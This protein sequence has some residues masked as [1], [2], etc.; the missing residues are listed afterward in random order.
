MN[1]DPVLSVASFGSETSF[2]NEFF[3]SAWRRYGAALA[4]AAVGLAARQALG[5]VLHD[6]V[7]YIT[8]FPALIFSVLFC[9]AGPTLVAM[10]FGLAGA[11]F[12]VLEPTRSFSIPGAAELPGM[13][14]FLAV[15]SV[16][17][18][19][20]EVH[21]R[22]MEALR[23]FQ[24]DL[25]KRVRERTTELRAA[26]QSVGDLTGR[27][28]HLQ[29]EERRRMAR[30]LHD[31]VGQSL[32]ALAMNL[33][34]LES[35]IER[36]SKVAATVSD[37]VSLVNDMSTDIRT[38]SHLLHPPLLD[39][40]GLASALRWYIDG[41]TERSKIQVDLEMPENFE[42][43]ERD[44]ETAIFRVVQECLTNVHRHSGTAVAKIRISRTDDGVY[45][46][47]EDEGKGLPAEKQMELL[48]AGTPGV[49]IRGMRERLRQLG[50]TLEI[51]SGGYGQGTK[52]AA[53]LPVGKSEAPLA[54][55]AGAGRA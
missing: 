17:A 33:A 4:A 28:L 14:L 16:I 48:A 44:L 52:V 45:L 26:N 34:N 5:P 53:M 40:A 35:D 20:G 10:I 51:V 22:R 12:L 42:R 54:S 7:P 39:E 38:I 46:E 3:N 18:A 21:R 41:F 32:A 25:E 49:G 27:L 8:L 1:S 50:G 24:K 2:E 37:S 47:V 19:T 29:D 36:I 11:R 55:V 13:F 23:E 30:E 9:G 31:G 6:S 43:L 15:G